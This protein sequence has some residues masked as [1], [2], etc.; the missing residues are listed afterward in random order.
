MELNSII[1]DFNKKQISN[2]QELIKGNLVTKDK[3]TMTQEQLIE[4]NKKI[5]EKL[6]KKFP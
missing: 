1:V 4:E 5:I 6:E 2:N 3:E